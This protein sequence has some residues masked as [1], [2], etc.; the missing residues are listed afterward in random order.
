MKDE[1][2]V[3][4]AG[5]LAHARREV[6]AARTDAE[7]VQEP[8][9]VAWTTSHVRNRGAA[10]VVAIADLLAERGQQR[11]VERLDAELVHEPLCVRFGDRVVTRAAGIVTLHASCHAVNG[12]GV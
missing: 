10:R 8:G 1:S 7:A 2:R 4:R 12:A 9:N 5:D 11:A 3:E 6:D